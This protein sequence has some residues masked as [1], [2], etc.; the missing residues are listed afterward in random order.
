MGSRTATTCPTEVEVEAV[1]VVVVLLSRGQGLRP[2]IPTSRTS[3]HTTVGTRCRAGEQGSN[4][5][6]ILYYMGSSDSKCC[7]FRLGLVD[8]DLPPP[9][10]PTMRSF[11]VG[12]ARLAVSLPISPCSSRSVCVRVR[13]RR[14]SC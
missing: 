8:P 14:S 12:G 10:P 13:A 2:G 6:T 11:K 3:S 5:T 1:V 7:A 4:N 9:G